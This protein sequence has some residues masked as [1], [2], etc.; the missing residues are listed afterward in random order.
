LKGA[1]QL[2]LLAGPTG[3]AWPRGDSGSWP[4][5]VAELAKDLAQPVV[6]FLEDRR[7]FVEIHALK[8]GERLDGR[9]DALVTGGDE[10]RPN[11]FRIHG[12][13][14]SS[15]A[16]TRSCSRNGSKLPSRVNGTAERGARRI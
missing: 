12:L 1:A 14:I 8:R 13:A 7:P 11:S 4:A 3:L 10:S 16:G 15:G 5:W 6:H 2:A 9:V